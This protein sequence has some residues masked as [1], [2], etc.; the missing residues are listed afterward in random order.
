MIG[1]WR[2]LPPLFSSPARARPPAREPARR[3]DTKCL[4]T[5]ASVLTNAFTKCTPAGASVG[6]FLF[7]QASPTR[8]CR[9]LLASGVGEADDGRWGWR[10]RALRA[11]VG[12][13]GGSL[14]CRIVHRSV[15]RFGRY[16]RRG[17]QRSGCCPAARGSCACSAGAV[18]F[19]I[20][21]R[22]GRLD[23]FR[24]GSSQGRSPAGGSSCA[25]VGDADDS[26]WGWRS[27]AL[28]VA[29]GGS[30]Q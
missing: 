26:R 4:L 10:S 16:V 21:Y 7:T 19:R 17:G 28:R 25:G 13:V 30:G 12:G 29:M 24:S 2:A 15:Q 5:C 18:R 8:P 9:G 22:D 3:T 27:R 11:G 20:G 6:A 1:R 23:V 14:V